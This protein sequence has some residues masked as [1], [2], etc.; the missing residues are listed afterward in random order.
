L[1][2]PEP[3]LRLQSVWP[4]FFQFLAF[5][6]ITVGLLKIGSTFL[7]NKNPASS[8][9]NGLGWFVPGIA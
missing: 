4:E 6:L 9:G 5:Y 3:V 1:R 8:V 7:L 2:R